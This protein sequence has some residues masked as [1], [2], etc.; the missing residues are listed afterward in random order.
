MA[1]RAEA[2]K[3]RATYKNMDAEEINTKHSKTL[4][5]TLKEYKEIF[6]I[7]VFFFGGVSWISAY[8][9]TRAQVE[10][11][12]CINTLNIQMIRGKIDQQFLE[13]ILSDNVAQRKDIEEEIATF[14]KTS[15]T[16]R[17]AIQNLNILSEQR[18]DFK[19]KKDAAEQQ[20]NSAFEKLTTGFCTK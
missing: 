11:V 2:Q 13:K 15:K 4:L 6:A 7:C 3:Y 9:A 14:D 19:D 5:E 1:S 10:E 17:D 18:K 8:F 12:R 20:A 16:Y